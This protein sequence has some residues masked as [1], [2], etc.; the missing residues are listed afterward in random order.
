[1]RRAEE[2]PPLSSRDNWTRHWEEYADS[3]QKNP[4]QD[5]RRQVILSL[6]D[7]PA[8]GAG[9]RLLDIGSGQGDLAAWI[10]TKF[11]AAQILGLEL[12]EAGV[13]ISQAKVPG[14]TFVQRN[15]LQA[16]DLPLEQRAW[17]T[18]A[19]C[20]EVIEHV[21][22]PATLLS[23]ARDYMAS[24]CKLMVTAPGGPMSM[25]DKHIG[26]RR[27]FRA[28]DI[29]ALLRQA[30]YEPKWASGAGFPFFNLYRCVVILRGKKLIED[31][32]VQ[33]DKPISSAAN[34]AMNIFQFLFRFNSDSS[35]W[36]WQ[37]VAEALK[38]D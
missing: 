2:F 6:L 26:H 5:Y 18:H 29:E 15:L 16:Q 14:G 11:P 9:V 30:G 19:V 28:A 23:N 33:K 31:V 10:Q 25:F 20:S 24:G 7:L 17:A 8:G 4:A 32:R 3:A 12:S 37:M 34:I 21:D 27:H 38:R 22:D 13:A 36:G 1:M 35:S